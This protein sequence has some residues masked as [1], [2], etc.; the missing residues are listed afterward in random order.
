MKTFRAIYLVGFFALAA[1]PTLAQQVSNS[2]PGRQPV[3]V[4]FSTSGANSWAVPANVTTVQI[5]A[6][7]GGAGGGVGYTAGGAGGGGQGGYGVNSFWIGVT[8]GAT[9]TITVGAKGTAGGA[10]TPGSNGG[11]GGQTTI[12][13]G[14]TH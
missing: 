7:G 3:G 4:V 9:L 13:G 6:V 5:D 12:T 2:V 11:A 8:P 10:G 14:L 1:T